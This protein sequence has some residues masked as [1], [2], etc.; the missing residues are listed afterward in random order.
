MS[1]ILTVWTV[2]E[3]P[4]DYPGRWV[5]RAFDVTAHGVQARAHCTVTSTLDAARAVLPPGLTPLGR[6]ADDDPAIYESW[7]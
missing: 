4:S 2:Y 6:N 1:G 7:V 3:N 5:V